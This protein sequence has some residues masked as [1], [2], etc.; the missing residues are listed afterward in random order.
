MNENNNNKSDEINNTFNTND[1]NI[2]EKDLN[3]NSAQSEQQKQN[4]INKTREIN[5][6]MDRNYLIKLVDIKHSKLSFV[7]QVGKSQLLRME[8]TKSFKI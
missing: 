4:D 7:P 3:Q 6:L 1:N 5:E 2:C 8:W